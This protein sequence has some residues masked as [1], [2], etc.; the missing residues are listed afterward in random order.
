MAGIYQQLDLRE[1]PF[2][3]KVKYKEKKIR[4]I[5]KKAAFWRQPCIKDQIKC[6][7]L[8]FIFTHSAVHTAVTASAVFLVIIQFETESEHYNG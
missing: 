8:E 1:C 5:I 2:V 6:P 3:M 7:V 4:I